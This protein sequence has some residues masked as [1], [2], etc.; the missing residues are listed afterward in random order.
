M[1]ENIFGFRGTVDVKFSLRHIEVE[2]P[3][4]CLK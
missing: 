2:M 1:G 4:E 3:M